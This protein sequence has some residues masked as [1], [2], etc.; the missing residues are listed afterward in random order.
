VEIRHACEF[1]ALAAH[2]FQPSERKRRCVAE[3][4]DERR[5][6]GLEVCPQLVFGTALAFR[7]RPQPNDQGAVEEVAARRDV[8]DGRQDDRAADRDRGLV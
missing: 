6:S 2:R 1:M 3:R 7:D 8:L 5:P 4:T